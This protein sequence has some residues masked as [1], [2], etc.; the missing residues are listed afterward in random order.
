VQHEPIRNDPTNHDPIL[1]GIASGLRQQAQA[2]EPAQRSRP[3]TTSASRRTRAKK[4]ACDNKR[5]PTNPRKEAGLRR[6]ETVLEIVK[7]SK[8]GISTDDICDIVTKGEPDATKNMICHHLRQLQ[9]D[10]KIIKK[11]RRA[12]KT[13]RLAYWSVA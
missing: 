8:R 11:V 4:P 12:T 13:T 1:L 9:S 6:I 7:S 5:K 10:G 2:D 3:A